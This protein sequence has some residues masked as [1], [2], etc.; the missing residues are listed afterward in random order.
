MNTHAQ[1]DAAAGF[2]YLVER[3]CRRTGKVLESEL[4]KNTVPMQGLNHMANVVFKQATQ[5]SQW[6]IAPFEGNYVP[7]G[8]ETAANAPALTTEST[9]YEETARQP[10]EPGDVANGGLINTENKAE[11]NFTTAKTVYGM[12]MTS[13]S[14]KAATTGVLISIVRFSSPK[15]VDTES[16]LRV[17]AGFAITSV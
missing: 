14:P 7:T 15:P 17:T 16:L 11:F 12:F 5:V 4:V 9:A 1:A 2:E 8:A 6:Y 3:I 10:F 13:A